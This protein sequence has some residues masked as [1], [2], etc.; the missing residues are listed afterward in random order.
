MFCNSTIWEINP[1]VDPINL[2]NCRLTKTQCLPKIVAFDAYLSGF[3][4][5]NNYNLKIYIFALNL[6]SI[7]GIISHTGIITHVCNWL[8]PIKL[9]TMPSLISFWSFIV[10]VYIITQNKSQMLLEIKIHFLRKQCK[11]FYWSIT[12]DCT[13]TARL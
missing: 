9:I 12:T 5:Q 1:S 6:Y 11:I 2:V 10:R 4:C 7:W 13:C 3:I 8:Q